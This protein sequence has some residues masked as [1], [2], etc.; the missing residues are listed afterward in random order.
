LIL[1]NE[2]LNIDLSEM[3]SNA[4]RREHN[5][6]MLLMPPCLSPLGSVGLD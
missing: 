2:F 3:K 4:K 1:P 5:L 6:A